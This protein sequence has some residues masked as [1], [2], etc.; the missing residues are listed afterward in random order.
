[1]SKDEP[2]YLNITPEFLVQRSVDN[3][4]PRSFLRLGRNY[5]KKLLVRVVLE[6]LTKMP[7]VK[8]CILKKWNKFLFKHLDGQLILR[9]QLLLTMHLNR[10]FVKR[11][12]V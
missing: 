9:T 1:M 7:L 12:I 3:L 6:L 10:Y 8:K 2:D 5:F 4:Y 11:D